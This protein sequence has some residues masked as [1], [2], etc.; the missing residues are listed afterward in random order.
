MKPQLKGRGA[1]HL[2]VVSGASLTISWSMVGEAVAANIKGYCSADAVY[3]N[4]ATAGRTTENVAIK[5]SVSLSAQDT[6]R[7]RK[8][9]K[10]RYQRFYEDV[11]NC[12]RQLE[13]LER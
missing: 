10:W 1:I 12:L 8:T 9:A 6:A 13:K 7:G 11:R 5:L 4:G 3:V 2:L